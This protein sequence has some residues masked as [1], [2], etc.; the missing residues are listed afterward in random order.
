MQMYHDWLCALVIALIDLFISSGFETFVYVNCEFQSMLPRPY[1]NCEIETNT[2][3]FKTDSS[4]YH[5]IAR[6]KYRYAKRLC[7]GQC[8]QSL[9]IAESNC[10]LPFVVSL[11]NATTCDPSKLEPIGAYMN[12]KIYRACLKI[13]P[14]E[15]Y[16]TLFKTSMSFIQQK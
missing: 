13:C 5:Q 11:F 1:S 15:C 10:S 14:F 9:S 3:K 4:F 16:Q 6:T 7:F 2:P 12:T 8:L